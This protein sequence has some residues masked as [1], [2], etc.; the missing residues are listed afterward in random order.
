MENKTKMFTVI[1]L[2]ETRTILM[3]VQL[4]LGQLQEVLPKYV[5]RI[6][7]DEQRHLLPLD[8]KYN[9]YTFCN[10]VIGS[11]NQL[12]VVL[13]LKRFEK[14]FPKEIYRVFTKKSETISKPICVGL[15]PSDM[16]CLKSVKRGNPKPWKVVHSSESSKPNNEPSYIVPMIQDYYSVIYHPGNRFYNSERFSRLCA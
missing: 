4:T 6:L 1:T 7:T 5:V 2:N 9:N 3:F 14:L 16:D 10:M 11:T 15:T 8:G 13:D 12:V